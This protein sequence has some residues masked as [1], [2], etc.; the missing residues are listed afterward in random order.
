ML[1]DS[2]LTLLY[3][4]KGAK[5][6]NNTMCN[7]STTV[8]QTFSV[9]YGYASKPDANLEFEWTF[10]PVGAFAAVDFTTWTRNK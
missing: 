5:M 4:V 1:V 10:S 9:C 2:I 3:W 8:T 6:Y 7:S